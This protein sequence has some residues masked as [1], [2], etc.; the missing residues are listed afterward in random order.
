M[1]TREPLELGQKTNRKPQIEAQAALRATPSHRGVASC[2]EPTDDRPSGN[3][4]RG[5][6]VRHCQRKLA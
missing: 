5:F 1:V 2:G 3:G 4:K 6:P